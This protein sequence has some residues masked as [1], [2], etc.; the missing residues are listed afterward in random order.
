[1][2][3]FADPAL[4]KQVLQKLHES[5]DAIATRPA[6][7]EIVHLE[8][9]YPM[10]S[11]SEVD[12]E[13]ET[14]RLKLSDRFKGDSTL[15]DRL[16]AMEYDIRKK[17]GSNNRTEYRLNVLHYQEKWRVD[18][19]V[20]F[21]KDDPPF[22]TSLKNNPY[23][24][25]MDLAANRR[26][27]YAWDGQNQRVVFE[28]ADPNMRTILMLPKPEIDK[29]ESVIFLGRARIELLS[30]LENMNLDV[31]QSA[32]RL[33]IKGEKGKRIVELSVLPENGY[34]IAHLVLTDL[35]AN[36]VDTADFSDFK[37][38]DGIWY[39]GVAVAEV[40]RI[41]GSERRTIKHD[42]WRLITG[43]FSAKIDDEKGE[44]SL[45]KR[46]STAVMDYN[47]SPPLEYRT[48][49]GA[50]M[51][52]RTI[53][54]MGAAS[55]MLDTAYEVGGGNDRMQGLGQVAVQTRDEDG[56]SALFWATAFGL[57]VAGV[58]TGWWLIKRRHH[59]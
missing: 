13:I 33:T 45:A 22:P 49:D 55:A 29:S 44:F 37:Q 30:A 56:F 3:S 5:R 9:L 42:E 20:T 36:R 28:P 25:H 2:A 1:M 46:A 21:Q 58:A 35:D 39:P 53:S 6:R 11:A 27:S 51:E 24:H 12:H 38:I 26:Q 48:E 54:A 40:L 34:S 4:S 31:R 47:F 17:I 14:Q 52:K 57:G 32:E 43:T 10:M 15:S 19:L 7:F 41:E 8:L 18:S 50:E 59:V 16:L 23:H